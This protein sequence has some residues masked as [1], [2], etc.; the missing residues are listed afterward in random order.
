[1][2]VSELYES[3][4]TRYTPRGPEQTRQYF[5]DGSSN[6]DII[7]N[8]VIAFTP[9]TVS[10]QGYPLVRSDIS[11]EPGPSEFDW[12]AD[13]MFRM[14]DRP[15]TVEPKETGESEFAFTLQTQ[16]VKRTHA[17]NQTKYGDDAP[18]HG[19]AINVDSDGR[20]QGVEIAVP[21]GTYQETHYLD[22]STITLFWFDRV[23]DIVGTTNDSTFRGIAAG[24]LLLTGV[25]GTKRNRGDWQVAF[26]WQLGKNETG[27]TVAG[28][29]GVNKNA[30]DYVWVSWEVDEDATANRFKATANG[31]Y[32]SQ[33]YDSSNY[34]G[35]GIGTT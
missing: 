17:I 3:R 8:S 34:A 9:A 31:V 10:V 1:M 29:S 20:V 22:A 23:S 6:P 32:V 16:T 4:R 35:L 5:V 26:D 24:R 33:V 12:M 13:V 21:V 18:D 2:A 30:H 15:E 27:L 19:D 25:S 7:I 28:I 11:V 14:P